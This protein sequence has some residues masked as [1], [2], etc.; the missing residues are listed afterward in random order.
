MQPGE[1]ELKKPDASDPTE[2]HIL[3]VAAENDALPNGKVGGLGDVIRDLPLALAEA[4]H[5]VSV[6]TPDY[7]IFVDTERATLRSR[8]ATG[9][10]GS[11]EFL[12]LYTVEAPAPV[13]AVT[14]WVLQHPLF[15]AQGNGRIY[16]T[17]NGGP[18]ATDAHRFALFCAGVARCIEQNQFGSIDILHCHDWHTGVLLILRRFDSSLLRQK[19]LPAVFSIHNLSLQGTRPFDGEESSL[20]HWFPDIVFD[21]RLIADPRYPDCVNPMRAGINLAQRVHT[22]SP[23][24][25]QEIL[26]ASHWEQGQVGGEGLEL[27]LQKAEREGRLFGILNGCDYSGKTAEALDQRKLW[28][29]VENELDGLVERFGGGS[30]SHYHALKVLQSL[31]HR[32]KLARPLLVSIGRLTAQKLF[33]LIQDH[34]DRSV[35][36]A[37]LD[38]LGD[39]LFVML[40]NGD[41]Y[42]DRFFTR[43][44][45]QHPNF[46]YLNGFSQSLAEALY[47]S[48]DLFVMPSIY[49]PCGISQLLAMR[50]GV[51]CL[52]HGVGGLNDTVHDQVNGFSFKG[53]TLS[54]KADNLLATLDKALRLFRDKPA[55][56]VKLQK[57]ARAT[58]YAWD[59]SVEQFLAGPYNFPRNS[60]GTSD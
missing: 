52:V 33:L 5:R 37:L 15:S 6:V 31:K 42:Y 51:P 50:A 47:A 23:T 43:R 9:F 16:I 59:T 11:T 45:Q 25:A 60:Q 46:L 19:A 38:R 40:G 28:L 3:L 21:R 2:M 57:A 20:Q 27:D 54:E 22:V 14:H 44:M 32:R 34:G 48:G 56:W 7:G 13:K 1:V 4:G 30:T 55:S 35:M 10:C 49:E 39:G 26:V 53:N 58:R 17:D 8:V 41:P 12:G 36:D 29:L 18:F 24:Y